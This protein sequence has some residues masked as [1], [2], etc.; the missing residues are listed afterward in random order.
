VAVTSAAAAAACDK[1]VSCVGFNSGGWYKYQVSPVY[2]AVGLCLYTK[3][4]TC[5]PV[6]GYTLSIN[7][8]LFGIDIGTGIGLDAEEAAAACNNHSECE[9]FNLVQSQNMYNLKAPGATI[10]S[11]GGV[12]LYQKKTNSKFNFV[13]LTV[14]PCY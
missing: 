9:G 2:T 1:D 11:A 4:S 14:A 3:T 12:C 6:D 13:K 7:S 10:G 8:G 5:Q